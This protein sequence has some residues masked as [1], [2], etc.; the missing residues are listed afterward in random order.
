MN[1]NRLILS[2]IT[3]KLKRIMHDCINKITG[4]NELDQIID[5]E[6]M[7]DEFYDCIYKFA[8]NVNLKIFLEIGSSSGNGSS[9]AFIRGF[10]SR[11][12]KA[13]INFHCIE[14]STPRYLRLLKNH[15][16]NSFVKAHNISSVSSLDFPSIE[17]VKTFYAHNK[18]KLNSID[19]DEILRWRQRD[20]DYIINSGK[21]FNGIEAIKLQNEIEYFDMVLIDGSEF[22]G[23][24]ELNFVIGA[25]VIALDDTESYKCRAAFVRLEKDSRYDLVAHNPNLRN[26]FAIFVKKDSK[27]S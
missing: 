18:T 22:T 17:E 15:Q 3:K 19:L 2:K 27:L 10:S 25:N 5:P 12:D 8:S 7:D 20:I 1:T 21:D 4:R 24:A 6:I 16:A 9:D 26:G 14:L 11:N 23:E 13:E